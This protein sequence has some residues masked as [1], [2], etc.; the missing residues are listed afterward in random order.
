VTSD[1]YIG[2]IK[3][4]DRYAY[5]SLVGQKIA[6]DHSIYVAFSGEADD[7]GLLVLASEF[8]KEQFHEVNAAVFDTIGEFT[9]ICGGL[10]ATELSKYNVDID[11][12]PPFAYKGQVAE[13]NTYLLP[14]Y[15]HGKALNLYIS[16]DS[17]VVL[18]KEPYLFRTERSERGQQGYSA[19]CR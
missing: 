16:V 11:M 17:Q 13:G 12:Q 18:G 10:L 3:H 19:N 5:S 2:K 4:V 14:I 1:F 15:L 9:N 8:A 6:G 7:D